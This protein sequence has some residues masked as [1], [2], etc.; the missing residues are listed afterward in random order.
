VR[1]G[2]NNALPTG[3]TY[4]GQL[5][6]GLGLM[7]YAARFY[8]GALG[9]FISPDT[10][11]PEPGNPQALN[12]YS[13]VL[14]NPL[15]YT[16]P[17]GMFSEDAVYSY[18]LNG[19][20]GGSTECANNMYAQW[21]S[22]AEWWQML[23]T[24]QAGDVLFGSF[25]IGAH[26]AEEF[27]F[28]FGGSGTD[29]LSGVYSSDLAGNQVA[30]VLNQTTLSD[31]FAGSASLVSFYAPYEFTWGGLI[32][33]SSGQLFLRES[34]VS[35]VRYEHSYGFNLDGLF[36][37]AQRA[38][39]SKMISMVACFGVSSPLCGIGVSVVVGT[40]ADG[41]PGAKP[42]PGDTVYSA[43]GVSWIFRSFAD[44]TGTQDRLDVVHLGKG[45]V[46][47][48]RQVDFVLRVRYE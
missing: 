27:A 14:N 33:F 37:R 12:R 44:S 2:P 46:F 42:G 23:M 36:G 22:N 1:P 29:V 6:S 43:G 3:Y 34:L 11:V 5:D 9:R 13:Y 17:T 7:Y 35:G 21:Q 26:P 40:L 25:N 30:G 48:N 47:G 31:I 20:C 39:Q 10:I 28:A 4:T 19:E 38:S 18:I 8:D 24:A 45:T 16:D 15:R 32:A 41:S